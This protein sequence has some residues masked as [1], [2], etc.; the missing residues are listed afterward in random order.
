[1]LLAEDN[2]VNQAVALGM[3][4]AMGL[5]VDIADNG[6]QAVDR[7]AADRYDLV[8]MDW[9]MPELDG[10][11]ATAEIRRR[12]QASGAHLPIVAL[13]AN[14]IDGDREICIAA[15]MDDYLAKPFTRGQLATTL[16]RWLPKS[17]AAPAAATP[18]P[19][20]TQSARTE[21]VATVA[22]GPINPRAL[23]AI[24]SL[25]GTD[26]TALA[27]KVICAYLA[28]TPTRL[29]Q[30][31]SAAGAGDAEALRKAAHGMKSS[32]GNVGA[33]RLAG[34]CKEL[35]AIGRSGTV[36]G[37]PRLLE[38][39]A[40]ELERVVAALRAQLAERPESALT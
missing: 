23:N 22:D 6:R 11:A 25:Q 34:L 37:A 33:D 7:F 27:K 29:G 26:G 30:M 10:F 28:D 19:S 16:A 38:G 12:E 13:T 3:L 17:A 35:E 2:P 20:S 21:P 40:G 39:A 15:G 8:L 24:R 9:Q 14:A 4:E 36:E 31:Q 5:A 1:V 32:S 18:A